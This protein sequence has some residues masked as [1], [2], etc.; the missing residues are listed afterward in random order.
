MVG[1][2]LEG[3]SSP[4]LVLAASVMRGLISVCL[5]HPLEERRAGGKIGFVVCSAEGR[6]DDQPS[7]SRE[8]RLVRA[9]LAA[10][11]DQ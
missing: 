7:W 5:Q 1:E 9:G 4:L 2:D 8:A 6:E 10:Q 11:V 3:T